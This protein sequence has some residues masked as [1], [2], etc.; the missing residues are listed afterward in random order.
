MEKILPDIL[1]K[2]L[3]TVFFAAPPDSALEKLLSKLPREEAM[4]A[5][6][7]GREKDLILLLLRTLDDEISQVASL[8]SYVH[9]I[10]HGMRILFLL[11]HAKM[12][13]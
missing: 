2:Q 8:E 12:E 9:G 11:M 4:A 6:L 13:L 3:N 10:E 7:D 1:M 5:L